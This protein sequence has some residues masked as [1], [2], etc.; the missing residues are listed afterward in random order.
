M[1]WIN[2]FLWFTLHKVTE[3][4]S[5]HNYKYSPILNMTTFIDSSHL[6]QNPYFIHAEKEQKVF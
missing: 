5:C 1:Y 3:A 6:A 4:T 2:I